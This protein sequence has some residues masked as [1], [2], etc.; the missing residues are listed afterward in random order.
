MVR[1][2]GRQL[3]KIQINIAFFDDFAAL[4]IAVTEAL[5]PIR[6]AKGKVQRSA[7]LCNNA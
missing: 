7:G 5:V 3:A 2:S 4:S 1:D 6:R